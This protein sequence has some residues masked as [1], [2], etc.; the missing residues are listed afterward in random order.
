MEASCF[1]ALPQAGSVRARV[2][3]A[4]KQRRNLLPSKAWGEAL[5]LQKCSQRNSDSWPKGIKAFLTPEVIH[6]A[7]QGSGDDR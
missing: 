6:P 7:T 2:G 5:W 4:L 1:L 3:L